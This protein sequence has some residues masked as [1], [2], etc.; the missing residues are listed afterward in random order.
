MPSADALLDIGFGFR[1]LIMMS[2]RPADIALSEMYGPPQTYTPFLAQ[3]KNAVAASAGLG[4]GVG[5]SAAVG[6]LWLLAI[7]GILYLLGALFHVW[8]RMRFHN[9]RSC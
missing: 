2:H 3:M 1:P 9:A 8:R 6:S 5:L 4:I 7:G